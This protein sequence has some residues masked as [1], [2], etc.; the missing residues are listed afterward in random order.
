MMRG[1]SGLRS[2]E[3][4]LRQGRRSRARREAARLAAI[5]L[6][7][8][9]LLLLLL[10]LGAVV[11]LSRSPAR[12]GPPRT[13][14]AEL[15]PPRIDSVLFRR[16]R[17]APW[18]IALDAQ[19]AYIATG[20]PREEADLSGYPLTSLRAIGQEEGSI[21]WEKELASRYL[22]MA[23]AGDR[24]VLL[25]ESPVSGLRLE[26]HHTASGAPVWTQELN[27]ESQG[28]LASFEG[29]V[30]VS[31]WSPPASSNESGWSI[32]AFNASDGKRLWRIQRRLAG[33]NQP[34]GAAPRLRLWAWAGVGGYQIG[35]VAGLL[36]LNN[37][38]TLS[39]FA[40]T[41]AVLDLQFDPVARSGFALCGGSKAGEFILEGLPT[42]KDPPYSLCRIEAAAPGLAL[43][44]QDGWVVVAY[45]HE[46][47]GRIA[48]M[49]RAYRAGPGRQS[50]QPVFSTR[51]EGGTPAALAAVP[52]APGEFLLGLNEGAGPAGRPGGPSSL[53]R[54]RLLGEPKAWETQRY[55]T[56][57]QNLA[58]FR[59][60]CLLLLSD[61]AIEL[62]EPGT[63]NSRR[64]KRLGFGELGLLTAAH[65]ECLAITAYPPE[66]LAGLPGRPLD[67][68]VLR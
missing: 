56:G 12:H 41:G 5:A 45:P 25:R 3:S 1:R 51:F 27:G 42:G 53:R 48:P 24:L 66:Y 14:V 40:G 15:P 11:W 59:Q 46:A 49:L 16:L 43:L 38:K 18:F 39:E 44:A 63:E 19:R 29:I 62:Y 6:L 4:L 36:R 33:L 58:A 17:P 23:H 50:R 9:G 54:I 52:R 65:G 35:N 67:L 10:L 13:P 26:A 68:L 47:E 7:L 20:A 57:I 30:M 34:P 64:L 55:R 37:G 61:G 28:S 2:R 8:G 60:G 31:G 32:T 22:A 21:L